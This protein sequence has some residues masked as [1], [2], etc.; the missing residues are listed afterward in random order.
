MSTSE[1]VKCVTRG[2]WTFYCLSKAFMLREEDS[3]G[4]LVNQSLHLSTAALCGETE[5]LASLHILNGESTLI[6]CFGKKSIT[7]KNASQ[8]GMM[9]SRLPSVCT[10]H[11]VQG[12]GWRFWVAFTVATCV[13][14]VLAVLSGVFGAWRRASCGASHPHL[15]WFF[16]TW[17]FPQARV[18]SVMEWLVQVHLITLSLKYILYQNSKLNK[19]FWN[20]FSYQ[21]RV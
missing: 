2:I 20:L 6:V 3:F 11:Y 19:R 17:F 8:H 5:P 14:F 10:K 18:L 7:R 1:A 15:V 13:L 16:A 4:L 9:S 21:P 12:I